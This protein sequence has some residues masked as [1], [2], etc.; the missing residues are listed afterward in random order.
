[1]VARAVSKGEI[2]LTSRPLCLFTSHP[3]MLIYPLFFSHPGMLI[4]PLSISHPGM[5]IY[6]TIHLT[7]RH[8]DLPPYSPHIQAYLSTPYP[9]HTQASV[10]QQ[11]RRQWLRVFHAATTLVSTPDTLGMASTPDTPGMTSTPWVWTR[12]CGS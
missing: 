12:R 11:T 5:L 3:G 4:Y 8:T 6:P 2:L 10:Q 1:M 9:S 7:S